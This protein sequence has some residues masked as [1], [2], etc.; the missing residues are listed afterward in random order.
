[1][2]GWRD[3]Q[4]SRLVTTEGL[5][6]GAF[7]A[8]IGAAVGVGLATA[9]AGTF[10]TALLGTAVLIIAAATLLAGVAALVPAAILRRMPNAEALADE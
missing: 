10:P 6:I 2:V 3:A 8:L 1:V 7:G 4:L 5:T 9:F